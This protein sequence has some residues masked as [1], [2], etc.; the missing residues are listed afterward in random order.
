MHY[1]EIKRKNGNFD[2]N[3]A[4]Y[5]EKAEHPNEM[6]ISGDPGNYFILMDVIDFFQRL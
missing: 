3:Q 4:L 1:A 5:S 6:G 2:Q